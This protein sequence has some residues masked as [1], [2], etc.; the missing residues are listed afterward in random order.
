MSF[1]IG[2]DPE[3]FVTSGR[4]FVSLIGK[5][6]GTKEKPKPLPRG[7]G[8]QEDNLAVEFNIPPSASVD[9]FVHNMTSTYSDVKDI[10]TKVDP[11]LSVSKRSV[12]TFSPLDLS[13]PEAQVFGCDPD[14]NAWSLTINPI[15]ALTDGSSRFAGGHVH[16]GWDF[17]DDE[18][19]INMVRLM[20]MFLGLPSVFEDERGHLRR[21]YYGK[22]GAHRP[23][24]YGIEYRTLSNYWIFSMV[25]M[26]HI[27]WRTHT[28]YTL[29]PKADEVFSLVD[30]EEVVDAINTSNTRAALD[31]HETL[32]AKVRRML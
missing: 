2:A 19:R 29:L 24:E 25:R 16:V 23:K 6:G 21:A 8:I 30:V 26:S 27:Y 20:D 1:T 18:E 28:A 11:N 22:A 15:P 3:V 14:F 12:A 31:L 32:D 5:V 13:V 7:G 9:E 10:I 4:E 17:K